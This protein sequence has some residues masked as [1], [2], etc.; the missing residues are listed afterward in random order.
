MTTTALQ[1]ITDSLQRLGV[2][3]PTE[4]INS[5]DVATGLSVLNDMMDSW[6]NESLTTFCTTESS[7]TLVP[8]Q[9]S[10]PVGPGA[11][12]N[13]LRPLRIPEGPGAARIRDN[14]SNDFDVT[15][16]TQD[17]WNTI[18][19]KTNTSQIPD[20]LFYDPQ[21]PVGIINIY[22]IPSIGYTLFWDSYAQ[23]TEFAT[24]QTAVSLPPGYLMAMKTNLAVE[25][26][27]YYLDGEI[28]PVILRSAS[29][30]LAAVKRTNTKPVKAIFDPEIVSRASPTYNIYRDG[31]N[32]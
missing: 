5:A 12:F 18:G 30:S 11:A 6:S 26:H 16:V 31:R 27:P 9:Q 23:L 29:R 22:P 24:A 20:T 3:N 17:I 2:Y 32:T 28:N 19:A 1:I 7:G 13:T 4:T 8:G 10:Y 14:N 25:L 21:F 15:V